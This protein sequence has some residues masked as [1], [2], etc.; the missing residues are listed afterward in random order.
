MFMGEYQHT[1]DAKGRIIIPAKLREQCG[2][3]IVITRGFDGAL[4][5]YSDAGWE[6]YF[7]KL[8]VLQTS[9]KDARSFIRLILSRASECEFDKSGRIN[10]PSVLI[11]E[12]ALS[13]ECII[14][15]AGD[16]MEIWDKVR[17]DNYVLENEADLET[18]SENLE[19]F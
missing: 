1:I 12:G 15:G 11:K 16:H 19:G 7:Q 17:W 4:S 10:I 2:T 13:K 8:Q 18:F 5:V 3:K 14:I 6:N 9:K